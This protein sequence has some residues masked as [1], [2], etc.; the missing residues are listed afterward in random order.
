VSETSW[1][2]VNCDVAIGWNAVV[3]QDFIDGSMFQ[4]LLTITKMNVPRY[5]D[6][7]QNFRYKIESYI[8]SNKSFMLGTELHSLKISLY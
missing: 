1:Y 7:I 4:Q 3:F 6:K 8:G 5:V 2:L